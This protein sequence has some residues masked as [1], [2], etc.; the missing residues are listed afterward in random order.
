MNAKPSFPEDI[1]DGSTPDRDRLEQATPTARDWDR[2]VSELIAVQEYVTGQSTGRSRG[3][4]D[5]V[6][7]LPTTAVKGDSAFVTPALISVVY[8][9]TEW[10]TYACEAPYVED[11]TPSESETDIITFE[12]DVNFAYPIIYV[13]QPDGT[14]APDA[15]VK[16]PEDGTITVDFTAFGGVSASACAGTWKLVVFSFTV[17]VADFPS[18]IAESEVAV[19]VS[20]GY[21]SGNG[22][23]PRFA[24]IDKN[25]G[26]D[27]VYA[28]SAV[29]GA[30]F[31]IQADGLYS[32]QYC[33][34]GG[35][36]TRFSI[37]KNL[38]EI[39]A[40]ALGITQICATTY[41]VTGDIIRPINDGGS[42]LNYPYNI[43]RIVRVR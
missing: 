6:A 15:V 33:H 24:T 14:I 18:E 28:D 17:P 11:F 19:S 20:N 36:S 38:T 16:V 42:T 1:W 43:F 37:V 2:V 21:A 3:Y 13:F 12:V 34:Q 8:S 4:F 5:T 26:P 25:V 23:F 29:S 41:C 30:R 9:G 35:S 27:I 39:L 32:I 7:E 40:S 22:T 10:V 31:E